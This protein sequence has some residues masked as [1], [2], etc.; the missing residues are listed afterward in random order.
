MKPAPALFAALLLS[1]LAA[2]DES[3]LSSSTLVV[4]TSDHGE[5]MGSHQMVTKQKLYEESAAVP[6]IIA[7]TRASPQVDR[8]HLV[9]GLDL[10]PT[11][12][13]YAGLAVPASLRG[14][15]L[16]PLVEGSAVP[17]RDFV[18]AESWSPRPA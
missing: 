18:A 7:P 16:R 9:S 17:W 14:H 5:M 1:F 2:L 13:D 8:Q 4:L 6:L 11:F 3:G 12:L 10:M 15:S